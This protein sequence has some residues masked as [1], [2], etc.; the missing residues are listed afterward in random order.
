[1]AAEKSEIYLPILLNITKKK[2][3]MIGAGAACREKLWS[4]GQIHT[5]IIVIAREVHEDFLHKDWI[6]VRQKTYEKSDL[7][8]FDI[9]YCGVNN[10]A[11]EEQ[12]LK[13]AREYGLLVNFV[14]KREFSDFISPSVLQKENF[15]IFISTFGRGPGAAKKIRREIEEKVDLEKLDE[16]TGEYIQ[17]RQS[18]GQ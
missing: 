3:L 4:L 17:K 9:V 10:P 2:I 15:S 6:E 5:K 13:D 14:D 8:G 12:I 16:M 1:M 18:R 11:V 7:Q